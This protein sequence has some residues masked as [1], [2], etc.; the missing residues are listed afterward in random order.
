MISDLEHLSLVTKDFMEYYNSTFGRIIGSEYREPINNTTF[1]LRL[2]REVLES[3]VTGRRKVEEK[4][5][6]LRQEW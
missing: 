1:A 6:Q 5:Y 2:A 3:Q 4:Y